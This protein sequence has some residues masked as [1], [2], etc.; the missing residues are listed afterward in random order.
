MTIIKIVI[1]LRTNQNILSI[2]L[3]LIKKRLNLSGSPS[4]LPQNLLF[5]T[6]QMNTLK[7][8]YLLLEQIQIL[9]NAL[10]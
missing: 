7:Y 4:G 3:Q 5:R 6:L 9:L 10:I 8:F 2:M 1:S